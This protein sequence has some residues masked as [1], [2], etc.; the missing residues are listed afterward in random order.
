[1]KNSEHDFFY[2]FQKE[3]YDEP[4]GNVFTNF[5]DNCYETYIKSAKKKILFF[6]YQT[7]IKNMG[8]M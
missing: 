2:L 3:I 4:S 8:F 1:M 7:F 5:F 6:D